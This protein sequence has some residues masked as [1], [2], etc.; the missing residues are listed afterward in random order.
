MDDLT[1]IDQFEKDNRHADDRILHEQALTSVCMESSNSILVDLEQMRDTD[2]TL[3]YDE[4]FSDITEAGNCRIKT[5]SH[6]Q[7]HRILEMMG[8][9]KRKNCRMTIFEHL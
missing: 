1:S 3:T 7:G 8:A 4:R 2:N 9:E 6:Q 5:A